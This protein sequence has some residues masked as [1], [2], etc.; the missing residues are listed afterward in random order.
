M[1][2]QRNIKIK[3]KANKPKMSDCPICM[4]TIEGTKNIWDPETAGAP[5]NL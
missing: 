2:Q 4:E 1:K 5:L 3:L